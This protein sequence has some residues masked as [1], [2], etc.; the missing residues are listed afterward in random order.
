MPQHRRRIIDLNHASFLTLGLGGSAIGPSLPTLAGWMDVSL[1]AAGGL[2]SGLSLGY[3]I[4]GLT[5]GLLADVLGRRPVYLAALGIQALSLLAF[6]AIPSTAHQ[7]VSVAGKGI[8]FARRWRTSWPGIRPLSRSARERTRRRQSRTRS[9]QHDIAR[10][11]RPEN[12]ARG[13]SH[14]P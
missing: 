12:S 13:A 3:M 4:A 2:V 14:P 8:T 10:R 6:V 11:Y 1:D 5:A 9:A 7:K